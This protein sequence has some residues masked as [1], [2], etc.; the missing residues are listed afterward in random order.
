[1]RNLVSFDNFSINESEEFDNHVMLFE[2]YNSTMTMLKNAIND[3]FV[4]S[5]YYRGEKPGIVDDG[6]RTIEPY[7]IG[8]NE[9]GN[10]VVRAW[11]IK[12][13][14]KTGKIDPSLVPGWRLFR[15]DRIKSISTSLQTF[16]KPRKGYNAKDS[17][18]T[19]VTFAAKF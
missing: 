6:Y 9:S 1:V 19:E 3:K 10:V 15:I 13:K 14:S 2:D 12:G 7:A 5:I 8:P 17:H 11:L 4:C 18:M 16:T